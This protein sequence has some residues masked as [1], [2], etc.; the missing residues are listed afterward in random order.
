M[1]E[2]FCH[3][4]SDRFHYNVLHL[5]S[6]M[7]QGILFF[8]HEH[9]LNKC[10]FKD[11]SVTWQCWQNLFPVSVVSIKVCTTSTSHKTLQNLLHSDRNRRN[12]HQLV[13]ARQKTPQKTFMLLLQL[14]FF[15]G[16]SFYF[17]I[18]NTTKKPLSSS[19]RSYIVALSIS[20]F[21][22]QKS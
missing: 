19:F 13:F 15:C 14:T 8:I 22:V 6:V 17:E 21:F 3:I 2:N 4:S 11:F 18:N 9:S 7:T 10:V 5:T 1:E 20:S 12:W 16:Q